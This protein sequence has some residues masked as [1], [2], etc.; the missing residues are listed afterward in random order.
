MEQQQKQETE[1]ELLNKTKSAINKD[2][3]APE[4]KVIGYVERLETEAEVAKRTAAEKAAAADKKA[5]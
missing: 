2:E 4:P 1:L 3:L 5:A